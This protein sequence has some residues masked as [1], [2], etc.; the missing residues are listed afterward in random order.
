ML[1]RH[2]TTGPHPQSGS[3]FRSSKLKLLVYAKHNCVTAS[4]YEYTISTWKLPKAELSIQG[5]RVWCYGLAVWSLNQWHPHRLGTCRNANSWIPHRPTK[6]DPLRAGPE[7]WA[8]INSKEML[9]CSKS[10]DPLIA[11]DS[12]Q[13]THNLSLQR[14]HTRMPWL[15]YCDH[16]DCW[17]NKSLQMNPTV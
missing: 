11:K 16:P 17:S 9:T 4:F 12:Q 1:N 5:T 14:W 7:I 3:V 13:P 10:S 15:H 2:S 8:L 6:P